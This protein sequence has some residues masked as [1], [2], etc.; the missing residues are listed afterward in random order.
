MLGLLIGPGLAGGN[1]ITASSAN[2][3]LKNDLLT[4]NLRDKKIEI[5]ETVYGIIGLRADNYVTLKL[6]IEESVHEPIIDI[7]PNSN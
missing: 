2:K 3:N 7:A 6:K 1:L 4:F 5:G